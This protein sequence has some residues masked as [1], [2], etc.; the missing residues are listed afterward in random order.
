MIGVSVNTISKATGIDRWFIYEIQKI[1]NIEKEMAKYDLDSLPVE[2]LR[3]AKVN[4]FSD[5]Q[6]SRILAAWRRRRYL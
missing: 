5:E 4:G 3:E 1:C 6:I 2:L